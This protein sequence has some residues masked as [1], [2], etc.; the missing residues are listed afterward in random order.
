MNKD[1]DM[2]DI[3]IDEIELKQKG[4]VLTPTLKDGY[5]TVKEKSFLDTFDDEV[6]DGVDG[7]L[8]RLKLNERTKKD[9]KATGEFVEGI[10]KGLFAG[11]IVNPL[12]LV[13]PD[14]SVFMQQAREAV[15]FDPEYKVNT[16]G[17]EASKFFGS[18]LGLGKL[19][20]IGKLGSQTAK[21]G[22]F[23]QDALRSLASTFTG[24]E[25]TDENLADA[26]IAMGADPEDFPVLQQLMTNPDDSEFE[27]RLK[28][29]LADLPIEALIPTISTVIKSIKKGNPTAINQNTQKL[30]KEIKELLDKQSVGSAINPEGELAQSIIEQADIDTSVSKLAPTEGKVVNL[31][32]KTDRLNFYSKAEEVTNQLKQ[33][34]G[35]GQQYRQQLLKAGVKPDEIEWLGLD[36]VLN[37]GKITKQELQDQ[38]NANRIELDEV[39][40]SG[41]DDVLG[42]LATRFNEN[43]TPMSA[44]DAYGP[45][46]LQEQADEIFKNDDLMVD[47]IEDAMVIAKETYDDNPVMK[48]VDPKTGYTITGNGDVGYQIFR[49][50]AE[51]S[52]FRNAI[53]YNIGRSQSDVPYSLNEAII[54]VDE[55]MMGGE[56]YSILSSQ[57]EKN[58]RFGEYTEPGGDNYREFLIKYNDPK[59]SFDE[60]HFNEENVI[61][62]FRTKD[63]TTSDGK[64]VFYIEE[65]Q[66]DWGQKGRSEG[67]E[68]TKK[69]LEDIDLK[70]ADA[71]LKYK[72]LLNTFTIK[73]GN[74]QIPFA[75][76]YVSRRKE[77]ATSEYDKKQLENIDLTSSMRDE[78]KNQVSANFIFKNGKQ[79]NGLRDSKFMK[80]VYD[81]Q[82]QINF[83]QNEPNMRNI[84]KAPFITDT[85]KWTQLTLKRIL[86]KAVDEGYD[87]VSITPGKAQMDRWNDEGVAK[88][89]DE[90]VPKNAE[91]IVKKLDKNAIQKDK[92]INYNEVRQGTV[93]NQER[94]SIELTPQLKE[95]VKKGMAMFSA[96]PLVVGQEN[97]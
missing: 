32:P 27:G 59:V 70:L 86:S 15:Q 62:H 25:S 34:K 78:F 17:Y 31:K 56:G 9:L 65:I 89:Y 64:K 96:T 1:I 11:G 60:S 83:Y 37:K 19:L 39:E 44:E 36:D 72:N 7:I 82:E 40:L 20:A 73:Q 5:V 79:V 55:D 80:E 46:Y 92:K 2:F 29:V 95:K 4:G 53:G 22:S 68:L 33:N 97:E 43:E 35:T 94:F 8:E 50:E 77:L 71:K 38:I 26:I 74:K 14:D 54:R 88:F 66:S 52:N 84:P 85:D 23:G 76:W 12:D 67:F 45:E 3:I 13:L 10:G 58:T 93:Y 18:F 49:S 51:S 90:I 57:A 30:E 42:G 6:R 91:K 63:R 24:Y 28:N 21:L 69:E 81:A 47:S 61:A 16:F 75:D 87:F 41:G 48:Y